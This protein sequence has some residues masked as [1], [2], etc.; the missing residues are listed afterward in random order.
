M[1]TLYP[2]PR[3]VLYPDDQ[4]LK[5]LNTI[6]EKIEELPEKIFSLCKGTISCSLIIP[7]LGK[8]LLFS[9]NGSLYVGQIGDDLTNLY[10]QKK[11]DTFMVQMSRF[12]H[13]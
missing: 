3:H 1:L 7:R 9:N 2:H 5:L 12:F 13:V 8:V 10:T 6:D 4:Q 11:R